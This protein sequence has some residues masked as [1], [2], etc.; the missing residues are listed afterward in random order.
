MWRIV[1]VDWPARAVDVASVLY[2]VL[3]LMIAIACF[4]SVALVL[5]AYAL[6]FPLP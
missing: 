2:A 3:L 6:G 4:T 1:F 5:A